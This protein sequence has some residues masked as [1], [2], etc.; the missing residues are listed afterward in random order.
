M[1]MYASANTHTR[2]LI[3]RN[4]PRTFMIGVCLC[5]DVEIK[6]HRAKSTYIQMYTCLCTFAMFICICMS[7]DA[8]THT[9]TIPK[10]CQRH[11]KTVTTHKSCMNVDGCVRHPPSVSRS[12]S[13]LFVSCSLCSFYLCISLQKDS[14]RAQVRYDDSAILT[15]IYIITYMYM[16]IC[17]FCNKLRI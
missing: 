14:I 1:C 10:P 15:Y 3:S 4:H 8:Y 6:L 16:Y 7:T 12:M 13:H 9:H 17:T 2:R 5:K 11:P